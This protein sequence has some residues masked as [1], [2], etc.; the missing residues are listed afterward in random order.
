MENE[1]LS[2]I[3]DFFEKCKALSCTTD[4]AAQWGRVN[5]QSLDTEC[6]HVATSL[7]MHTRIGVLLDKIS[8][9][10][11][12]LAAHRNECHCFLLE[13]SVELQDLLE[14]CRRE[15]LACV[16]TS[17]AVQRLLP[18]AS[19]ITIIVYESPVIDAAEALLW[20]VHHGRPSSLDCGHRRRLH[21]ASE[22]PS[23]TYNAPPLLHEL[24]LRAVQAYPDHI[25]IK[26][27]AT[28]VT[29]A[30]L[31]H[32]ARQCQR[33]L[34]SD[35]DRRNRDV[36]FVVALWLP[37][38]V[39]FIVA[40]LG[41]LLTGGT[42][43][44]I[45]VSM[46]AQRAH[47]I[48]T[49]AQCFH[50]I[51]DAA[52]VEAME[53][54]VPH[55]T[56][57]VVMW[58]AR[59]VCRDVEK[60]DD[61]GVDMGKIDG[62]EC[63]AEDGE[64]GGG[65][66]SRLAYII[67]TSGSTG[68]PKGVAISH[69]SIV[70]LIAWVNHTYHVSSADRLLF[71][72]SI[73]FDLSC[74]DV[75]GS[76]AAGATI[77]IAPEKSSPEATFALMRSEHI[78]FWDSAPAVLFQIKPLLDG[79]NHTPTTNVLPS[80]RLIFLS[81]DWIPIPL[82]Q[83]LLKST[84]A[85]LIAL[86][87]ATEVTVWSNHFPVRHIDAN[88]TSVPYGTAI[89]N[90][91]YVVL[92]HDEKEL[93][94]IDTP[95]PLYIG[96]IGVA[97]EYY[98]DE[99]LT[100]ERFPFL[101]Y[102]YD[103]TTRRMYMTGDLCRWRV[104]KPW[105]SVEKDPGPSNLV[106]EFLGR[107]DFQVKV[108]GYR[109]ETG[110]IERR[111]EEFPSIDAA[112][113]LAFRTG[114]AAHSLVDN[115]L[116]AFVSPH[117]V[118]TSRLRAFLQKCLPH[119]MVPDAIVALQ[120]MPVSING[121]VDR[122]ALKKLD[123]HRMAQR[124][125]YVAPTSAEERHVV[126]QFADVLEIDVRS[127]G[128]HDDFFT[129]GGHSIRA[130]VLQKRLQ[131]R[132]QDIFDLR[133]P[134]EIATK[135]VIRAA[136]PV[137]CQ[138]R[139]QGMA[140]RGALSPASYAQER[141]WAID[142]LERQNTYNIPFAYRLAGPEFDPDRLVKALEALLERHEALRTTLHD[143]IEGGS[144]L[145]QRVEAVPKIDIVDLHQFSQAE[146][147]ER[148]VRL[149]HSDA[150]LPF[151]LAE[152]SIRIK[153]FL[154]PQPDDSSPSRKP[155][156]D[157]RFA[158]KD[159]GIPRKLSLPSN[160]RYPGYVARAILY[161]NVH[162]SSFDALS[163]PIFQDELWALYKGDA[164][165]PLP[166][167]YKDFSR[168]QQQWLENGELAHQ[169][170]YWKDYLQGVQTTLDF[171]NQVKGQRGPAKLHSSGEALQISLSSTLADDVQRLASACKTTTFVLLLATYGVF[172]GRHCATDELL[173]GIPIAG[174]QHLPGLD[175][176]I[177]FFVN[178]LPIRVKLKGTFRQVVDAVHTSVV[179]ALST[180]DVPWQKLKLL[181][182]DAQ[183]VVL[184]TMFDFHH[185]YDGFNFCAT[186]NLDEVATGVH[187][188]PW[189]VRKSCTILEAG[190][191][192]A[193][194]QGVKFDI[195]LDVFNSTFNNEEGFTCSWEYS[196]DI[197]DEASVRLLA[198]RFV[199]LLENVCSSPFTDVAELQM[200]PTTE[201]RS[202]LHV[203]PFSPSPP[204]PPITTPH[205]IFAAAARTPH[206]IAIRNTGRPIGST[207]TYHEL[208][209]HCNR[210]HVTL[211][212]ESL[213]PRSAIG[214]YFA[215]CVEFYIAVLSVLR[216]GH[217]FVPLPVTAPNDRLQFMCDDASVVLILHQP[218]HAPQVARPARA[219]PVVVDTREVSVSAHHGSHKRDEDDGVEVA[220]RPHDGM[221]IL[222]T[223]GTT[224]KPKGVPV[225][226]RAFL[227]HALACCRKF[228]L[229]PDDCILQSIP[230]AFDFAFSQ[231]FP[232]LCMG[233]SICV[234]TQFANP[235]ML[236]EDIRTHHVTA[237]DFVPSFFA[238]FA[239]EDDEEVANNRTKFPFSQVRR[240][241]LGGEALPPALRTTLEA[242]M[243]VQKG[244]LR[245]FNTYGPTEAAVDTTTW[246]LTSAEPRT[247]IGRPDSWRVVH[248][249]GAQMVNLPGTLGELIVAGP[250]V[251]I[252]YLNGVRFSDHAYGV[253]AA[254][255]TG[256]LAR[257][258][259]TQHGGGNLEFCG[260]KDLQIKLRGQRIEVEEIENVLASMAQAA[261]VKLITPYGLI[262]FVVIGDTTT[263]PTAEGT[264]LDHCRATLPEYMV[265]SA[266][267]VLS[268][269][270]PRGT[271]GKIDRHALTYTPPC[272]D[273][274]AQTDTVRPY[275]NEEHDLAAAVMQVLKI[276]EVDLRLTFPRLGGDSIAAIRV[277]ARMSERYVCTASTLLR[278]NQSLCALAA[279]L[280]RRVVPSSDDAL[281]DDD[282]AMEG[283]FPLTPI[284]QR[285]FHLRLRV[286]NHYNQSYI[287]RAAC[288]GLD[289]GALQRAFTAVCARHAMLRARFAAHAPYA[290]LSPSTDI[291]CVDRVDN[292]ETE[293][294]FHA[295]IKKTQ[296]S[297]DLVDGPVTA[298]AWMRG[299]ADA[300]RSDDHIVWVVHH[301][302]VDIVSW[303]SLLSD[304][305]RA[306][307]GSTSFPPKSLPFRAYA[308][309]LQRRP[310]LRVSEPPAAGTE[311]AAPVTE[312][313][314]GTA[315]IA[316]CYTID[317]TMDNA[318][319]SNLLQQDFLTMED[320]LLCALSEPLHELGVD[321]VDVENH[322]RDVEMDVI[323]TVGWFT[324]L[325]PIALAHHLAPDA[326]LQ[327]IRH[328]VRVCPLNY[329]LQLQRRHAVASDDVTIMTDPL[330]S[331]NFHGRQLTEVPTSAV[332]ASA[333]PGP[334]DR[335]PLNYAEYALE[336]EAWLTPSN[337]L[338]IEMTS[339]LPRASVHTCLNAAITHLR[340]LA[341]SLPPSPTLLPLP[342]NLQCSEFLSCAALRQLMHDG[343]IDGAN[344]ERICRVS[345][346]QEGI[347]L[348]YLTDRGSYV[349][350][351]A[352][353]LPANFDVHRWREAWL[354]VHAEVEAMRTTFVEHSD[355]F[356]MIVYKQQ[357]LQWTT[358]P[359][360]SPSCLSQFLA[361]DRAQ[362]F[363]LGGP[364]IRF[365]LLFPSEEHEREGPIFVQTEHHS[366][367]DGW[368]S[369]LLFDRAVQRYR[370]MHT[371]QHSMTDLPPLVPFSEFC[372]T[373]ARERDLDADRAFWRAHM[374][375]LA[376]VR[377]HEHHT[378]LHVSSNDDEL[379][380]FFERT[381]PWDIEPQILQRHN[382]TFAAYVHA[383]WL[384]CCA[385]AW[386]QDGGVPL[387]GTA[388]SNRHAAGA[389]RV[390]GMLIA[391]L[392][393]C[394]PV[395]NE[396]GQWHCVNEYVGKVQE[397]LGEVQEHALMPVS[398]IW[399]LLHR[400]E[401][402]AADLLKSIVV[403]EN[404]PRADHYPKLP[405]Q[406][407]GAIIPLAIIFH[408]KTLI[409]RARR[410]TFPDV[411]A[412]ERLLHTYVC[413]LD[414]LH[415]VMDSGISCEHI[416]MVGERIV[417][418]ARGDAH[419]LPLV[420]SAFASI[421]L[422]RTASATALA[423]A[424]CSV[425]TKLSG[426]PVDVC[427]RDDP[428]TTRLLLA[429]NMRSATHDA[430]TIPAQKEVIE[431]PSVVRAI[432]SLPCVGQV[433]VMQTSDAAREKGAGIWVHV[434]SA[435]GDAT[436]Y[437][438]LGP[439]IAHLLASCVRAALKDA[440][441][442]VEDPSVLL[443]CCQGDQ[444]PTRR[445]PTTML[446]HLFIRAAKHH[447]DAIAV[448]DNNFDVIERTTTYLGLL[449]LARR[450]QRRLAPYSI[451]ALWLPRGRDFIAV[452][453]GV[454]LA[455]GTYVPIDEKMPWERVEYIVETAQCN[456]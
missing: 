377:T 88:W 261:C 338:V 279:T 28:T 248:L 351:Q 102:P 223:S 359:S 129:L 244:S 456:V 373:Q 238:L 284:M 37:R 80:L 308:Q 252:G 302:C 379:Y 112:V 212:L 277:A 171:P 211:S 108:R 321:T 398:E 453:A 191:P 350:Q 132:L 401:G 341:S 55:W 402:S 23:V 412:M 65:D 60:V 403:V 394:V 150:H 333:T 344:I 396:E 32:L 241:N 201:H 43:L 194:K 419:T 345:A 207:M 154:I 44:P 427:L 316:E 250:G 4:E 288:G 87:G 291:P 247:F 166:L 286:P 276:H 438:T 162:H 390:I 410:G 306:Y 253:G 22:G 320:M 204:L 25:A 431:T 116:V 299:G 439:Q 337:D 387:C 366:L 151:N 36:P 170:E 435:G 307:A 257:W 185:D 169:M 347:L 85:Q 2:C 29:Y 218:A 49:K 140:P 397:S 362:G 361:T 375:P 382:V 72:A 414:S 300:F 310:L 145:L 68:Q 199:V 193:G 324:A 367:I 371:P 228:A 455:K 175:K 450:V 50:V 225:S 444:M 343:V 179:S 91:W 380:G 265:P 6:A 99:Q 111:C 7:P 157:L 30:Q 313:R 296:G 62:G 106:L 27:D 365:T 304:F 209:T 184:H 454:L 3:V 376:A 187:V 95:G 79:T 285:F 26:E 63:G 290:A 440:N 168:W 126:Q 21:V 240:I 48:L 186:N 182:G 210:L 19:D 181:L 348:A 109:V 432:D 133:T 197:F 358:V 76:L 107:A 180:Q 217:C 198:H 128:V 335:S 280:R 303:Q 172:L 259:T 311:D 221:Y 436:L 122:A 388:V 38:S 448:C 360:S 10:P 70:H 353:Q 81:G 159:A 105:G 231:I 203:L 123:Y 260:R 219:I 319:L 178:T 135:V 368:S 408:D 118:C 234:P 66:A 226:H 295:V 20:A 255:A 190:C 317:C 336:V 325:R 213:P 426:Q 57:G 78:T 318:V 441:V 9:V 188:E 15:H 266:I 5:W 243:G 372:A 349:E 374:R 392:P 202:A 356:L 138:Y 134:A 328:Q 24:F 115:E 275:T 326:R 163:V 161:V 293:G 417:L 331:V 363:A 41:V 381:L 31:L 428:H 370:K 229:T 61:G 429:P 315:L 334:H 119:Y 40:A 246:E 342:V 227:T 16:V 73:G 224:G 289:A 309:H 90:H 254:Y 192:G 389:E 35:H 256:D 86:G 113:V 100:D 195:S 301:L 130:M 447:R 235:K 233:A 110:E 421:A 114:D 418:Q 156:A 58:D 409:W 386:K 251:G 124:N 452:A 424:L 378:P 67:F 98:R 314:A 59:D 384:L 93:V 208:A 352:W 82:A 152:E 103:G 437:T 97:K 434:C 230:L 45:D 322:G 94:G 34:H 139:V 329:S 415:R 173:I 117:T 160:I 262:A 120:H 74:Y 425:C 39:D 165:E 395:I 357:A 411:R 47:A 355:S 282:N 200:L 268:D 433:W 339:F 33:H 354:V 273:S 46:P 312:P 13:A 12:I 158:P 51:T 264:L 176:L 189:V 364:L 54:E 236:I 274:S 385:T 92:G 346:L 146:A 136:G 423:S 393:L 196:T 17:S 83:S 1:T 137:E 272:P 294:D 222:Y 449:T 214:L 11:V 413:L 407:T 18:E 177:G 84:T 391:T 237:V 430:D 206:N 332:F 270:F 292:V 131:I 271:S 164:L 404:Y 249:N 96:G 406:S 148:L 42:Y 330:A 64:C 445:D 340:H 297:L 144:G 239:M 287:L 153:L 327:E 69:R 442:L 167:Q 14:I 405:T 416:T 174:R 281:A 267:V 323:H 298:M 278:W 142:A 147:D 383:A 149:A 422:P 446:H 205:L 52:H 56:R 53:E 141:L 263:T 121:K 369:P 71:T 443:E 220:A 89:A 104:L 242:H 75:F 216:A 451:V 183:D 143:D 269:D 399:H 155:K 258:A 245:V 8:A 283:S 420:S 77:V 215:H 101:P 125:G 127:V 400:T 232:P 305:D